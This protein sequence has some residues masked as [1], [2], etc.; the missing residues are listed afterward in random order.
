MMSEPSKKNSTHYDHDV[1]IIG[2]G[3][4]GATLANLLAQSGVNVLVVD[5]E[6]AIYNLPRA[7]HFDDETMRVFQAVGISDDLQDKIRVNPGMRFVDSDGAV[8]L[9]WPRPGGIGRQGWHASYRLHQPDLENLLRGAL[10][11]YANCTL[12]L[13]YELLT[14]EQSD[15]AV[16]LHLQ[17][18]TTEAAYSCRAKFVVGCDGANSS[19]RTAIQSEMEDLGFNE[20]W[21]VLDV[22][23][24]QDI[25]EL[26]DRTIQYCSSEQPMTYCRNPGL[27]RRWEMAL[28][29]SRSDEQALDSSIIWESLSRWITPQ[30]ATLER[31]AIYTFRSQLANCWRNGRI[32]IA[33]DAAHLTPP[34]MGQGMC[35]GIRDAANLAWKLTMVLQNACTDVL[36][37]S[38]QQE[39]SPHVREYITTAIALGKLIGSLDRESVRLIASSGELTDLKMASIAPRLGATDIVAKP[40]RISSYSGKLFDQ[41][42]LADGTRLDNRIGYQHVLISRCGLTSVVVKPAN[43]NRLTLSAADQLVLS[44]VLEQWQAEAVFIRPD[45]YVLVTTNDVKSSAELKWQSL[46]SSALPR[47]LDG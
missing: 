7:V 1:V 31:K 42:M 28:S 2:C 47:A 11:Q 10:A 9:D 19:V 20:R 23:L 38:Y 29:D 30:D 5:R 24:N 27:R 40:F 46:L 15:T 18:K 6:D 33:G 43:Q 8:L 4:T 13:G 32:L 34:F 17:N 36:L 44:D 22:L 41:I 39:R 3:P 37:D 12:R 35:A 25:P 45:R 16:E 21:L 14:L 26:G